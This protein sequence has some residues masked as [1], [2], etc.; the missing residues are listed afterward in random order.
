[1]KIVTSQEISIDYPLNFATSTGPRR[2]LVVVAEP[3][4][5]KTA[6]ALLTRAEWAAFKAAGDEVFGV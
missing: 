1:M 2:I 6:A 4:Y 5:E 3:R